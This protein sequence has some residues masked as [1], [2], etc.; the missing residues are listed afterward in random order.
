MT[1]TASLLA[2]VVTYELA[3][4]PVKAARTPPG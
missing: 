3:R 4:S 1:T 2:E